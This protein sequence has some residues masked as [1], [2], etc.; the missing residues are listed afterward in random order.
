MK[1]SDVRDD[2]KERVVTSIK[3]GWSGQT[4]EEVRLELK[5]E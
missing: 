4:S 5:L 1:Q 2:D 3:L